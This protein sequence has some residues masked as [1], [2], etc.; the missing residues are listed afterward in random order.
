MWSP[1]ALLYIVVMGWLL[2][3]WFDEMETASAPDRL[4]APAGEAR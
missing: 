4:L 1:P 2:V 3:R